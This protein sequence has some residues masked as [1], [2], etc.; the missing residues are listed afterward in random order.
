MDY[1]Q[2]DDLVSNNSER[3]TRMICELV[4]IPTENNPPNGF[5]KKGQEYIADVFK[6][7]G[8][9][10]DTFAPDEIEGFEQNEAFLHGQ[11][12]QNGRKNVVGVWEGSG[13]GKSLL[14]CGHMDVAPKEPLPWTVCEPYKSIVKDGRIYGRGSSDMKGGLVAGV[15]AVRLLWESG[16]RPSGTVT[17]E[18]VVDEE[19]ASGN[20][21]IASR[22]R[23]H[24]AD[25]GIIM[26]PSGLAICPANV[27][28][29]MVQITI[30]GSAGMPYTG[31]ETFNVAYGLGDMLGIIRDFDKMRADT[32][33]P[34][35][36]ENAVQKRMVVVTKV[37]AGEVKPHGQLGAPSDAFIE[38][39]VQS[40]PGETKNSIVDSLKDFID[41]R[42]RQKAHVNVVPIY[43]YVAPGNTDA[44][45]NGVK[46]LTQ[47][48]L[49][50][51]DNPK[52]TAAPFPC[53]LFALEKYGKMPGVIFGPIGGN[54]HAPDE[55][56]DID[57]IMKL[58]KTLMN[59]IVSW[60]S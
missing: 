28:S 27:G 7:M 51:I 26:E 2:I 19:Y 8:L 48:A 50:Y 42:F 41:E 54:L 12:Y 5:E 31:E 52:V 33:P 3:I 60:C 18:S 47:A 30:K 25:F 1:K 32:P 57:S 45:G 20:G 53:D 13:G 4:D 38:C 16:F 15:M 46:I 21:T 49:Q 22:F 37:K 34:P 11:N 24:N 9:K 36:W 43:N 44:S 55:W 14:L 39:S 58:T 35:I 10:I 59:M 40:Y 29:I 23:G 17:I 6:E 56:V